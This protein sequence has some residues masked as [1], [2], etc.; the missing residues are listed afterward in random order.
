MTPQPKSV[1]GVFIVGT[2]TGVGKTTVAAGLVRL[3]RRS[4]RR[5][6]PFKPVETGCAPEPLDASRLWR[7]ADRPLSLAEICPFPLPL[8]AA[9]AAAAAALGIELDLDDLATRARTA[10]A[11]GDCLVVE[12][13][14]GLLTPYGGPRQ[15]NAELAA[16]LGLPILLVARTAL[17]TINHIAL[18]VAELARRDLPIAALVLVRTQ[19][20][21]GPHEASNA[22]LIKETTGVAPIGTI[23]WLSPAEHADDER[24][25]AA[26]AI[27]FP[28][29]EIRRLFGDR[30]A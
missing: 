21:I 15:T 13:A 9:P 20:E 28:E 14:G 11:H 7:A 17:G 19:A 6:I 23:P 27:L 10:A 16:R 26:A 2:D 1:P 8:P 30:A 12:G 22:R 25:A 3:L 29:F 5:P 4:G 18:T 24:L